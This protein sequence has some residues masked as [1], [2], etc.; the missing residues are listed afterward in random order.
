MLTYLFAGLAACA[1]AVSSVLQRKADKDESSED[2]LSLRLIWDLLHKPV[3]FG[4]I[5]AV[6]AGFLL[7]ATA[8]SAGALAVVEPVLVLE[9]PVTLV[10][11]GFVFHRPMHGREWAAVVA[12]TAGLAG[13]LYFLSPSAGTGTR[14]PDLEWA[15]GIVATLGAVAGL[16]AWSLRPGSDAR[17]AALLGVA[18]GIS[19]GLTAAFMKAMTNALAHGFANVFVTW[20]TYAMIVTGALAMFLLQSALNA[21]RLVAAQPGFTGA[22]PVVSIL[23][24]VLVF[25]EKVRGGLYL[26]LVGV[27]VVVAAWGVYL[28]SSSPLLSGESSGDESE[29]GRST[30]R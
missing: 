28:L 15:L 10:L 8:L 9:L 24:G 1:N 22:D 14:V 16:V 21:G 3:W 19:F 20:Q 23:W 2:N 29:S 17:R 7:Q 25:G 5:L 4:G 26:I 6:I 30:G 13:L 12:I 11:A 18:T 27:S